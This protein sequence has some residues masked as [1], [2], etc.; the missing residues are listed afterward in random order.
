VE[1]LTYILEWSIIITLKKMK[2]IKVEEDVYDSLTKLG[3][4]NET[5]S[6]IVKKTVE[7][8]KKGYGFL[9]SPKK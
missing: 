5:F 3:S 6:D 2:G 7:Y 8:Y 1:T 4:K 9:T